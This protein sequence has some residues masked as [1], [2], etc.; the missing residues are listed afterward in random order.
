M[1]L[2]GIGTEANREKS[3][4]FYERMVK[5]L[6]KKCLMGDATVCASLASAYK[7]GNGVQKS[8]SSKNNYNK[9]ACAFGD[10]WSCYIVG[11]KDKYDRLKKKKCLEGDGLA[12]QYLKIEGAKELAAEAYKKGCDKNDGESC[13][14]YSKLIEFTK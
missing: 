4:I 9:M 3:N 7:Y 13:Y 5:G 14:R 6:K 11:K 2:E 1:Y 12:C 10:S 8:E